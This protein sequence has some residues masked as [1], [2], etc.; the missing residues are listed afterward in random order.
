MKKM[1]AFLLSLGLLFSP[2]AYSFT[3]T[4]DVA[5]PAGSDS[6]T[7][8]DDRI[9]ELKR[10]FVER[11]AVDHTI[12]A[13]GST[14]DGATVGYHKKITLPDQSGDP[15]NVSNANILYSKDS[16]GTSALYL[17]DE[18]G[19][20]KQIAFGDN[21]R[22]LLDDEASAPATAANQGAVYTKDSGTQTELYFREESS[23]DEVQITSGGR[24]NGGKILQVVNTTSNSVVTTGTAFP[25]DDS[26]PQNSEGEELVTRAITPTSSS[27]KLLIRATIPYTS[28][29]GVACGIGIF[30]DSTAGALAA[31]IGATDD[32]NGLGTASLEH[33]MDAGTTSSTTFKIRGGCASG[34]FHMN[35]SASGGT[36]A[37]GGVSNA[38]VTIS[39]IAV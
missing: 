11:F 12:P 10:G 16:S 17:M 25:I 19:N 37:F 31:A 9:R 14:Y 13:S 38:T 8:G 30:Q 5:T 15:T 32:S 28:S 2:I 18:S 36:R 20:V 1:T 4:L 34:N 23:G 26:I 29:A 6:P 21:L 24:V 22:L 7:Q 39:E 33:Y 27:N 3:D 35:A